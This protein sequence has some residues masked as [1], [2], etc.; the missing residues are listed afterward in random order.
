MNENYSGYVRGIRRR[1][2]ISKAWKIY[3]KGVRTDQATTLVRESRLL[4]KI[5]ASGEKKDFATQGIDWLGDMIATGSRGKLKM[6]L[7]DS[8]SSIPAPS[9]DE[10]LDEC[11]IRLR[12]STPAVTE[13]MDVESAEIQRKRK[14]TD[15]S[16]DAVKQ[17]TTLVLPT[18]VV[19]KRKGPDHQD[20]PTPGSSAITA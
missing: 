7:T 12:S 4:K 20:P 5:I 10:A 16:D 15:E 8:L 3:S 14:L 19:K 11:D 6:N 9:S 17:D 1:A 13:D 18:H 2:R